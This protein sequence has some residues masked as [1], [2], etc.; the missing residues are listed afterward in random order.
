[1]QITLPSLRERPSDVPLLVNHYIDL[2]N[3]D[4]RK[5]VRG[6][7]PEAMELLKHYRWPGNVRELRNAVERAMLLTEGEWLT[8]DVLPLPAGR[9]STA[10]TM[11]LPED[12]SDL[13]ALDPDELALAP[14]MNS[15]Y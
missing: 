11:E 13:A 2:F 10:Q 15:P 7:T 8:A 14:I 9:A 4:F 5:Q 3:R 1:M 12:G 6:V